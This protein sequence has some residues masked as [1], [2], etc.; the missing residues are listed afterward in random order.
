MGACVSACVR[1][2]VLGRV[3]HVWAGAVFECVIGC[4]LA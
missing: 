2:R 4:V 3:R 1:G